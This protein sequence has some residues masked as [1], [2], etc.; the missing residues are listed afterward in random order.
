M[1]CVA[2][3]GDAHL[4]TQTERLGSRQARYGDRGVGL[5]PEEE[6]NEL[7]GMVGLQLCVRRDVALL[8]LGMLGEY[9]TLVWKRC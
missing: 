7:G 5:N 8:V 6:C 3:L 9:I 4:N 2:P 1:R